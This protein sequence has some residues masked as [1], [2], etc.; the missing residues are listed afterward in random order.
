MKEFVKAD[1]IGLVYSGNNY[2]ELLEQIIDESNEVLQFQTYIF[3]TDETGMRIVEALKRAA[4]RNV[5]VYLMI[6][7]FGSHSFS[8]HVIKDLITSGIHFRKFSPLFSSESIFFGRRLHHKIIVADKRIALTG[9]I[10]VADKY[11]AGEEKPWLDYGI[12]TEGTVCE[13]L[14]IL[15][16]NAYKKRTVTPLTLWERSIVESQSKATKKLVSFRINDWIKNKNEIYNS[17]IKALKNASSSITIISSYFLPDGKIRKLLLAAVKKGVEVKII[18][19]GRSD[20]TSV[21]LAENYLYDFYLKNKINV[22]EWGNSVMHG[23]AMIIDNDW[24][25]IGSYNINFLS[26]Y[27]SIELNT[28]VRDV[29][30]VNTFTE[31]ID[32]IIKT[33]CKQVKETVYRKR[34]NLFYR[35]KTWLAYNFYRLLMDVLVSKRGRKKTKQ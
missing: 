31:H 19:A 22:Y 15:C 4:A 3:N 24:A 21:R 30:F 20:V 35:V 33:G 11:N 25:T 32:K 27:I 28:E 7:A 9:G 16:E 6:D 5:L 14:H 8:R 1:K 2:F 10:N 13:Y 23:K 26:R 12:L 18:L 34:R 17:Y 29:V